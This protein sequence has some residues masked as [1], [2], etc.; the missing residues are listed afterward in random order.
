MATC[1]LVSFMGTS[2]PH[3]EIQSLLKSSFG[4]F[5][6]FSLYS[7][8]DRCILSCN[9]YRS[10]LK[11][12]PPVESCKRQP[13]FPNDCWFSFHQ[14]VLLISFTHSVD[15]GAHGDSHKPSF[16]WKP[17]SINNFTVL[18]YEVLGLHCLEPSLLSP[19]PTEV[20][21]WSVP[22]SF[23]ST[24]HTLSFL[25]LLQPPGWG[26]HHPWPESKDGS[27]AVNLHY[28]TLGLTYTWLTQNFFNLLFIMTNLK[29]T[30]WYS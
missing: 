20:N 21:H 29:H 9:W 1:I 16:C 10:F 11:P 4:C 13:N 23:L 26:P 22:C 2:S 7:P 25:S 18:P 27:M 5:S 19:P 30:G 24:A 17:I 6:F 15:N 28:F 12:V 14:V 8:L 3:L